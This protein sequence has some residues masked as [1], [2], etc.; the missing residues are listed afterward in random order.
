M[1]FIKRIV[2]PT[3]YFVKT[4]TET[5]GMIMTCQNLTCHRTLEED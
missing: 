1:G 4:T 2:K 3:T 5:R